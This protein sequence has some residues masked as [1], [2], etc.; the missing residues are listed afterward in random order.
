MP[1]EEVELVVWGP[2]L[3][4]T[5]AEGNDI[6]LKVIDDRFEELYPNVTV[7]HEGFDFATLETRITTAAAA[8]EGPTC[9]ACTSTRSSTGR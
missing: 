7:T 1:T 3:L 4:D 9:S 2:R 6:V 5:D 8:Q